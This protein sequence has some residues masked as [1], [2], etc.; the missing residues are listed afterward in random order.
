MRSDGAFAFELV[1]APHGADA[2][3]P[4][5]PRNPVPDD[6]VDDEGAGSGGAADAE[7]V[8]VV[9][10]AAVAVVVAVGA[11]DAVGGGVARV[12]WGCGAPR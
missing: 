6:G 4:I 8:A 12:G 1:F 5:T 3:P 9:V 10:V 2:S 11:G 7:P